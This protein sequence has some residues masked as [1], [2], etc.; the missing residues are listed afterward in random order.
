MGQ[1]QILGPTSHAEVA[2]V[3]SARDAALAFDVKDLWKSFDREQVLRGISMQVRPGEMIAIIGPSGSGKSTLLRCLN[4]LEDFEA[5]EILFM[6]RPVGYRRGSNSRRVRVPAREMDRLRSELGMVF[7]NFNLFPHKTVLENVIEAP[8]IVRRVRRTDAIKEA[9]QVLDS[10]GL[11]EKAND[12]PAYLSGGQQQRAA[13]ARALAMNPKAM[14]FDEPTSALDP[15]LVGEVLE[16]MQGLAR[17]GMT[18]IVVTHEMGF[19]R[20]VANRV[21][22]MDKGQI[23]EEG[24]PDVVF[25]E[26]RTERARLFLE[27]VLHH[28]G[29]QLPKGRR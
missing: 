22:V 28:E 11:A 2:S 18:M 3:P 29:R 26:P 21:L 1:A 17:D 19:A 5:G 15:E 9:K 4:F 14:L 25:T 6:G 7:Q 13:I 8:M 23:V 10:V 27:R 24:T 16:V 12:Y 20:D